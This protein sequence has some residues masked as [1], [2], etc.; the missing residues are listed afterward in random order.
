MIL[1]SNVTSYSRR[2]P[3]GER[4]ETTP[5]LTGPFDQSF[6]KFSRDGRFVAYVSNESGDA[7]IYVRPFPSG[8]GKWRVS[9]KGG[10]QVRWSRS[11]KELF[12]LEQ[13]VL[14][15]V[16]FSAANGAFAAGTPKPLFPT[17]DYISTRI[18]WKY[19][20]LPDG[21]F[22]VIER[23]AE[24]LAAARVVH[25]IQNWPALLKR[26]AGIE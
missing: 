11:G 12:Y 26:K 8:T 15:A 17:G 1:P 25:V 10:V 18:R 14:M 13:G 24:A 23:T 19:D 9:P 4:W 6:A 7:E 21:R 2:T 16:S 22:V 3:A 20:E 5:Y